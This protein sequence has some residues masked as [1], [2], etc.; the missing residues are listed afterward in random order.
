ML[1]SDKPTRIMAGGKLEI[2]AQQLGNGETYS[3]RDFSLQGRIH[4]PKNY[5]QSNTKQA[6]TSFQILN[7]SLT[8]KIKQEGAI[9]VTNYIEFPK[10][11]DGLFKITFPEKQP[12][13]SYLI[14]TNP[15]FVDKGMYLGSEYFFSRISFSPDRKIRLLGDS[16]YETKLINRAVL[17]GTGKRYLYSQDNKR[18][19]KCFLTQGFKHKRTWSYPWG[20]P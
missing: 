20:L 5:L 10:G 17:E 13:F 8:D 7:N 14:E 6:D 19:K 9:S 15:W 4:E 16:Y 11:K 3:E 18:E 1:Y 2:V 12:K